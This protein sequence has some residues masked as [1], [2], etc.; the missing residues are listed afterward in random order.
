ML[1]L[2]ATETTQLLRPSSATAAQDVQSK[3][4]EFAQAPDLIETSTSKARN[5]RLV[6]APEDEGDIGKVRSAF[7]REPNVDLNIDDKY[8]TRTS[9]SAK[10]RRID[11][12][13]GSPI[14]YEIPQSKFIFGSTTIDTYA[15]NEFTET[16]KTH[17]TI[18]NNE[19]T[20]ILDRLKDAIKTFNP[21]KELAKSIL[22]LRIAATF[23]VR[24]Q[25]PSDQYT[26]LDKERDH[27]LFEDNYE[28]YKYQGGKYAATDQHAQESFTKALKSAEFIDRNRF[29]SLLAHS[30]KDELLGIPK[31]GHAHELVALT[32]TTTQQTISELKL[33]DPLPKQNKPFTE[34]IPSFFRK[35]NKNTELRNTS[36]SLSSASL[37]A[38]RKA[39]SYIFIDRHSMRNYLLDE[40]RASLRDAPEAETAPYGPRE[41]ERENRFKAEQN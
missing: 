18:D 3:A 26:I 10:W 2:S 21:T 4:P 24:L 35:D 32:L 6:P 7:P 28:N 31:S 9:Q 33:T 12:L 1:R 27:F 38:K 13:Q 39:I 20:E 41:Q 40:F 17:S 22:K 25:P 11:D 36:V 8:P 16:L 14:L 37:E 30:Y 34:S 23:R 5:S 15:L 29:L 19:L